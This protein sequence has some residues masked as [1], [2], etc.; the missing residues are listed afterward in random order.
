MAKNRETVLYYAPPGDTQ[1]STVKS[2]LVRLGISIRNIT[3]ES[4]GQTI[5]CLLGRK[6]FGT[7]E[8]PETPILAEPVLVMDGFHEKRLNILL[9]ELKKA[10][11]SLPY[12]AVVTE[13]NIGWLFWQ[14]YEELC[15]EHQ[16]MHGE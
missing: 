12:K 5:G 8:A 10:G 6:N 16:A 15:A 1:T 9:R 13:T 2:V 3:P 4:T 14:L 11:V 7:R